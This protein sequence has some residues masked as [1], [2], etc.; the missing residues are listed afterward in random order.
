MKLLLVIAAVCLS[1]VYARPQPQKDEEVAIISQSSNQ[2]PDGGYQWSY[3]A[4]NGIKAQEVG[5][6]KKATGPDTS[7]VII[8]SGS[9]SWTAPDGTVINL[10][11]TADDERGFVPVGDHLP[12]P[13]PVPEAI[14]KAV[15]YLLS[16]PST[17]EAPRA[18]KK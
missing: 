11:Y 16:L 17:T 4:A 5:T 18:G 13:P 6:I 9:A 12:T 14:A 7:D 2:D 15:E 1:Y 10:S 3:E 8:T